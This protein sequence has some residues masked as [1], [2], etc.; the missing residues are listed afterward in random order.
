MVVAAVTLVLL[1]GCGDE[2]S[3]GSAELR[4]KTY[5][6]TAVTEDGKPKTLAPNTR[7]RLQFMDDGR[8]LADAGCNSMSGKVSTDDGKLAI[9]DGLAMTDLGCDAPRH[10]QDTWLSQLL[11]QD[12]A[13]KLEAGRLDVTAAG[14]TLVLADR[15]TADPDRP[16]DGTRWTV[17][18]L[19]SGETASTPGAENAYLTVN[20]GRVTGSTGC[21]DL[22]GV[23]ARTGDKLTFGEIAITRRACGGQEAALE[24][25]ILATVQGEVSFTIE[26]N[27]LRLRTPS[28]SGLDLTA[29]R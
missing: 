7:I 17:E 9:G 10:A 4:G 14:T 22:Q 11:Q 19:I 2:S 21:N 29:P 5:L 3:P 15:E 24:K 13:W 23:V 18:T 28:G 16:L 25:A 27:R 12:P 26:A 6:S 20:G 1:A 8:L